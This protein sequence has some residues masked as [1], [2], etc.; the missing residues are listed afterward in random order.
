MS[1]KYSKIPYVNK[2]VSRLVFGTAADEFLA[3]EDRSELLDSIVELG[4]NTFD[5]ARQYNL[6]EKSIG[7]WIRSRNNRDKVVLISKC[8]HHA[9]DMTKRVTRK[10]ILEDLECSLEYL[11]TDYID[12][13]LLHRDDPDVP[14]GDVIRIMNE[15]YQ[16]GKIGAFGGSNWSLARI[17]EA[18]NYA[19]EHDLI[20]FS[21]SSPTFGVAVLADDM[22]GGGCV[23][24]SGH[25]GLDARR[26]FAV[27]HMPVIVYS[28]LARGMFTGRVKSYDWDETIKCLDEYALKGY[29]CEEN[30]ILLERCEKIASDH[31]ESVANIAMAWLFGQ[32]Y[33]DD[34][35]ETFAIVSTHSPKRM[36]D[37]VRAL[38]IKLEEN[39]MVQLG[40]EK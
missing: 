2:A 17:V 7:R 10:D 34:E 32:T 19:R 9:P 13:Y 38:D 21:I 31:G 18:N 16:K 5:T 22:F 20:P 6:S 8:A 33:A 14:A 24:I 23:S 27:N 25:Q 3:G 39:E 28:S 15:L 40:Y 1:M 11:G 12:I 26:Y 35:L 29:V 30:R 37:N 36:A 4:I